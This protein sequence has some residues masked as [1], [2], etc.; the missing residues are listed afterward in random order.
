MKKLL[1]LLLLLVSIYSVSAVQ[2]PRIITGH[3]SINTTLGTNETP[4]GWFSIGFEDFL[5]KYNA[6]TSISDVRSVSFIEY[7]ETSSDYEN[8]TKSIDALVDSN[9]LLKSICNDF[10]NDSKTYYELYTTCNGELGTCKAQH[11]ESRDKAIKFDQCNDERSTYK[12]QKDTCKANLITCTTDLETKDK[13]PLGSLLIGALI[14]GGIV[15]AYIN[16][17]KKVEEG[18]TSGMQQRW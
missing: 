5:Q 18:E 16:K 13:F 11:N 7:I 12:S 2:E 8:F 4:C 10:V 3:I 15:F 17:S 6:N 14:G 9:I 1:I